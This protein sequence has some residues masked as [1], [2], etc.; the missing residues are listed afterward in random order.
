M[1][2]GEFHALI[3]LVLYQ[4]G[5]LK[6]GLKESFDLRRD[7][8]SLITQYVPQNKL[9]LSMITLIYLPTFKFRKEGQ[10]RENI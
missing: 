3:A 2:K 6:A 9:Y 5:N 8:S 10:M 1:P 7:L 4:R